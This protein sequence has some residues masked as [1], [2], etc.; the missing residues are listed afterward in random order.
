[1]P[2]ADRP[3]DPHFRAKEIYLSRVRSD[4][5][6][7]Q[8]LF[9]QESTNAELAHWIEQA[10]EQNN[11]GEN[12]LRRFEHC[13]RLHQILQSGD[14]ALLRAKD[15]GG[16]AGV[17]P[18][19]GCS[20][21]CSKALGA[22]SFEG[23]GRWLE[24]CLKAWPKAFEP[25]A[26]GLPELG[27]AVAEALLPLASDPAS[28]LK[29]VPL[30]FLDNF[31]LVYGPDEGFEPDGLA[32]HVVAA[33]C[34]SEGVDAWKLRLFLSR[35]RPR[36]GR[37]SRPTRSETWILLNPTTTSGT[38]HLW[39][40]QLGHLQRMFELLSSII[41]ICH[42][43]PDDRRSPLAR[44]ASAMLGPR[45]SLRSTSLGGARLLAARVA[46]FE[47]LHLARGLPMSPR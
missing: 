41:A 44:R 15:L 28:W 23:V 30:S 4:I 6:V 19:S 18:G 5:E 34:R 14:G 40:H 11:L 35:S 27:Q 21:G 33:T 8:K 3:A 47:T 32:A 37:P 43:H 13:E 7:A 45:S 24:E 22:A 29:E 26:D 38:F 25:G 16:S 1:M 20:L 31:R 12:T 10:I 39:A 17:R 9:D 36:P 46:T 2:R 42:G